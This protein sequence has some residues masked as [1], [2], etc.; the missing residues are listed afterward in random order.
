MNDKTS[1]V[2]LLLQDQQ[3]PS[4]TLTTTMTDA[5]QL[6]RRPR[7]RE[8]SSRF[9]S[10][11]VS[12]SSSGDLHLS[13]S[14]CFNPKHA[15][16]SSVEFHPRQNQQRSQSVQRRHGEVEPLCCADENRLETAR[17]MEISPGSQSKAVTVQRKK[18]PVKLFKENGGDAE[19]QIQYPEATHPKTYNNSRFLGRNG[20][21]VRSR[22]DTPIVYHVDR[23][24]ARSVSSNPSFQRSTDN[25]GVT[26]VATTAAAKLVQSS[27]G[28]RSTPAASSEDVPSVTVRSSTLQEDDQR[29]ETLT[30]KSTSS[31][32]SGSEA[33]GI[34]HQGGTFTSHTNPL[35]NC[36]S[37]S[38]PDFRSSMPE[39]DLLPTLSTRQVNGLGDSSKTSTSSFHR[40]LISPLP[41]CVNSLFSPARSIYKSASVASK[42]NSNS[43]KTSG[44]FL[45][46][47]PPN[48]KLGTEARKGRKIS[49]NQEDVHA[50]R[51]LH[52]H[53]LQWRYVNAKAET[54]MRSHRTA[55]E[56]SLYALWCNI[57]RLNDFV[58]RKGVEL[59]QLKKKRTL[60]AILEAQMPYLDKWSAIEENYSNSL[61]GATK[62]LQDT[63]LRLPINGNVKVDFREVEEALNSASKVLEIVSFH[64]GSFLSKAERLVILISELAEVASRERALVEECGDLLTKTHMLQVEECSLRGQLIQCRNL[65][66]INPLLLSGLMVMNRIVDLVLKWDRIQWRARV[67]HIQEE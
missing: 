1:E 6:H 35:Q 24:T 12:S 28:N 3:Q 56:R 10:P 66:V 19:H 9:M 13:A 39:A 18:R 21:L 59:T 40:S 43:M 62:A 67:H 54:V 65:T 37:R 55:A 44:I 52:N 30:E 49:S 47:H 11:V 14:K 5:P 26:S 23:T 58:K 38:L 57:S 46:P 20:N 36:K 27:I 42:P 31:D 15:V 16:S 29:S 60:S 4:N 8:V 17:S 7:V 61:S 22:P 2:S 63:L 64:L 48:T 53:Y 50:L 32:Y 33:C 25:I 34:S 41:S 45:P 51:L